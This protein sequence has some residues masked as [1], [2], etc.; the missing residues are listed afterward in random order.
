MNQPEIFAE[1]FPASALFLYSQ[2]QRCSFSQ[3]QRCSS[4]HS[5]SAVPS[6]SFDAVPSHSFDAVPPASLFLQLRCSSSLAVPYNYAFLPLTYLSF[7]LLSVFTVPS[8]I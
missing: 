3:L 2:L 6:H 8:Y 4:T 7:A 1:I 5:F